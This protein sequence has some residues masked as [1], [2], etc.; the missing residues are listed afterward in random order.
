MNRDSTRRAQMKIE[1]NYEVKHNPDENSYTRE[2]ALII[3]GENQFKWDNTSFVA[4]EEFPNHPD[5][6][7]SYLA[8]FIAGQAGMKPK[9]AIG[10]SRSV[11]NQATKNGKE[12]RHVTMRRSEDWHREIDLCPD[13]LYMKVTGI[14]IRELFSTTGG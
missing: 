6:A 13:T 10:L 5:A 12:V 9:A 3:N 11:F 8:G 2:Y 7:E 1:V 14:T 4:P